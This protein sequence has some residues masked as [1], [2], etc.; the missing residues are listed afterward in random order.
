LHSRDIVHRAAREETDTNKRGLRY[1]PEGSK[2]GDR[3]QQRGTKILTKGSKGG[4]RHQ[5]RGFEISNNEQ[6]GR[7]QAP[8]RGD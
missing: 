1:Q 2:G 3:H 8:T 6:L 7:R 4:D 5:Q